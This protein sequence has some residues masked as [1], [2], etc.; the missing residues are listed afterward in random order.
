MSIERDI[1]D[2]LSD[3]Q[4]SIKDIKNFVAG[5]DFTHFSADRK[6]LCHID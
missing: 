5:M 1:K 6:T 3:I 4:E 2:Y